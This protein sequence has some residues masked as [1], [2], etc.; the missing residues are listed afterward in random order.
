MRPFK[1]LFEP[2]E[3]PDRKR[4]H[5]TPTTRNEA[6]PNTVTQIIPGGGPAQHHSESL[7]IQKGENHGL[8]CVYQPPVPADAVVDIVFVHGLTGNAFTTWYHKE[9]ELHWPSGL[10][11]EDIPN[12][13]I[14][15][16][17]YDADVGSFWGGA[18]QNRLTNHASNMIGDLVGERGD[19]ET[20]SKIDAFGL[21]L[22]TAVCLISG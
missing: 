6:T 17:G 19:T 22:I 20:V 16:F 4:G 9:S 12:A 18:S 1:K 10:L 13:R 7:S 11:K 3:G 8:T 2:K 14:F 5:V 21:L 15:T